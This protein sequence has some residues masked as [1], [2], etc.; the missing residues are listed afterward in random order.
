MIVLQTVMFQ[1][2]LLYRVC[3]INH[4]FC[5]TPLAVNLEVIKKQKYTSILCIWKVISI[6]SLVAWVL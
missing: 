4:A 5:S 1:K 6:I 2:P 3:K